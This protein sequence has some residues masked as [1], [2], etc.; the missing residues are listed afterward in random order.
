MKQIGLARLICGKSWQLVHE[1]AKFGIVGGIA[2]LIADIG[3]NVL[4]FQAG[5]F[6]HSAGAGRQQRAWLRKLPR[7]RRNIQATGEAHGFVVAGLAE[8]ALAD[9]GGDREDLQLAA[10]RPRS[11]SISV[12]TS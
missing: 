4:H 7:L 1:L 12:R 3:T 6:G 2:V 8:Q 10:R 9:P 5:A 11:C